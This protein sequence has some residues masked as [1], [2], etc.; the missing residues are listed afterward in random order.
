VGG[1]TLIIDAP[2]VEA[3][4]SGCE[5]P[6]RLEQKN[7]DGSWQPADA[8]TFTITR[9]QKLLIAMTTDY[10]VHT[11]L[12]VYGEGSKDNVSQ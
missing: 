6:V 5:L 2:S 3:S 10:Y 1:G 12:P 4:V 7:G 9:D 8:A 11:F